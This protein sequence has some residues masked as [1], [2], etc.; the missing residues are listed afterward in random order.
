TQSADLLELAIALVNNNHAD[1]SGSVM[2]PAS[3]HNT[4]VRKSL[5]S[6]KPP[7]QYA[8]QLRERPL[9]KERPEK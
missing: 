3:E 1:A 7:E 9:F 5:A 8:L 6:P 2:L 4:K